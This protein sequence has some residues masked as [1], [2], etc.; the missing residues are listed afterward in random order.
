MNSIVRNVGLRLLPRSVRDPILRFRRCEPR[1]R[2]LL[3]RFH[4]EDESA[5][6][7]RQVRPSPLPDDA[8]A[9]L[10]PDNP[11]LTELVHRYRAFDHPISAH[12]QW[13]DD[14]LNRNLDLRAFRGDQPYVWQLRDLNT[15]INYYVTF[16]YLSQTAG[17]L[18]ERLREDGLFGSYTVSF[19]GRLVSRD[20][21]DAANEIRF[22]EGALGLSA[23]KGFNILDIG[24]GYGR[25][26][27]RLVEALPPFGKIF[28]VDAVPISTFLCEFYL[29]FR[30]VDDRASVVPLD[31]L[32]TVLSTNH[33]DL[34]TNIHSF[35]ECSLRAITAWIDLLAEH[36][37]RHLFIVPNPPW[38][39]SG[40]QEGN[41]DGLWSIER[42]DGAK[43]GPGSYDY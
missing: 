16:H 10:R 22:L 2:L 7:E 11:R 18:L 14:Y 42:R 43:G 21:L 36:Q 28:C 37:V 4:I 33:I 13:T 19:D 41:R 17:D 6:F 34:A 32:E 23:R 26:A 8:G 24:A 27:H 1:Y 30:G 9:Y 38:P 29:R 15:E 35:S 3:Q 39:P 31:E 25:L 12:S 5:L 20:L 40:Q